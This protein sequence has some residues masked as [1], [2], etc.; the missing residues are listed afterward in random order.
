MLAIDAGRGDAL[1]IAYPNGKYMLVDA[2]GSYAAHTYV[3]PFLVQKGVTHLDAIVCTHEHW[4]NIDGLIELLKRGRFT[5]DKAYDAGF[6]IVHN[7]KVADSRE[8]ASVDVYRGQQKKTG[9]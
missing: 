8:R 9:A 4:D 2:S 7:L 6:P 5:A 1:L 3:I